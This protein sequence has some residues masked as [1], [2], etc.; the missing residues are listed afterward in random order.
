MDWESALEKNP[1]KKIETYPAD[2]QE[3][4]AVDSQN[5]IVIEKKRKHPQKL[6]FVQKHFQVRFILK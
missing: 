4:A 3:I 5:S 2:C 6:I 1:I